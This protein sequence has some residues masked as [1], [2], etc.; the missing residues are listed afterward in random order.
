MGEKIRNFSGFD[1]PKIKLSHLVVPSKISDESTFMK[2]CDKWGVMTTVTEPPA[3]SIRRFL[4]M[5]D[6]CVVVVGD[7]GKPQVSTNKFY[8]S[9]FVSKDSTLTNPRLIFLEICF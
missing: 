1:S 9:T 6:W 2:M 3:E 8:I 4:Y 7:L 5:K